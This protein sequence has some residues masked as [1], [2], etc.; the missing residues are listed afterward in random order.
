VEKRARGR[1]VRYKTL[2]GRAARTGKQG[3]NSA[4]FSGRWRGHKL[5]PGRYRLVATARDAAGNVG[6]PRRIAFRIVVR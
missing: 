1:K 6:K 3:R 5:A 2:A 4:R